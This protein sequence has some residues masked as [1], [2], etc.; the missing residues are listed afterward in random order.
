MSGSGAAHLRGSEALLTVED[1]VVTYQTPVGVVHAVSEVSFDALR[2]ETVGIVGESGCGKSSLG[3]AVVGL[4]PVRSGRVQLDGTRLEALSGR[5][6]RPYRRRFQMIFQ[7]PVASLNPRR[8]VRDLVAEGLS[9]ARVPKV[10]IDRQ[11]A[12]MLD[13]VGLADPRFLT[14]R[15]R[16]LSGGQAQRVAIAR[17]LAVDPQVLVCDEP[18]S[19]LDVSVQAQI[20]NLIEDLKGSMDLTVVF[21]AHDLGVVKSISDR[22]LVMYLGRTCEAGDPARI[23]ARPAHPY[24]RALLDSV[25][26]P[27]PTRSFHG[28]PIEGDLPSPLDPPSGCHF[29]T[30]C[31]RADAQCSAI[32]PTVR[33]IAD[34]HYVACHHPA[35]EPQLS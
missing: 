20:L 8:H 11:V 16:Q 5:A 12:R 29:R 3:R 9:I 19:A 35:V 34:D 27:D 26:Q 28:P 24:T 1:L 14:M 4:D 10:D 23:Y 22:L 31:P 30:R 7:D 13:A 33:Q 17:A 15:P 21:I 32:V 2:G 6:L 25:P 18:V